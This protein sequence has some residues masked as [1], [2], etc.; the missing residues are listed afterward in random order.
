MRVFFTFTYSIESG[1]PSNIVYVKARP[2]TTFDKKRIMKKNL[3][4]LILKEILTSS[5]VKMPEGSVLIFSFSGCNLLS[6][7]CVIFLWMPNYYFIFKWSML[8]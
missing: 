8:Q 5:G 2:I 4:S 1:V 7:I 3:S 6:L